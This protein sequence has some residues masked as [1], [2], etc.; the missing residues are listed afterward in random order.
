MNGDPGYAEWLEQQGMD[1]ESAAR[2]AEGDAAAAEAEAMNAQ[3]ERKQPMNEQP[4]PPSD[5]VEKAFWDAL[6]QDVIENGEMIVS[7]AGPATIRVTDRWTTAHRVALRAALSTHESEQ[8][9]ALQE[10]LTRIAN[11]AHHGGLV[12]LGLEPNALTE[13]RRLTLPY[14]DKVEC[15]TLHARAL[16]EQ[17]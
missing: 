10:R 2:Q 13:I 9:K 12:G 1:E 3:N 15:D 8:V 11:I 16:K 14:W 6:T 4:K 7:L 17:A 5:G